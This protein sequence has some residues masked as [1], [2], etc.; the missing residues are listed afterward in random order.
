VNWLLRKKQEIWVALIHSMCQPLRHPALMSASRSTG[1]DSCLP[2]QPIQFQGGSDNAVPSRT[3][4]LHE[5]AAFRR[6][7]GKLS[8]KNSKS[9]QLWASSCLDANLSAKSSGKQWPRLA[10][11]V[12]VTSRSEDN[13]SLTVGAIAGKHALRRVVRNAAA[14]ADKCDQRS[15][16]SERQLQSARRLKANPHAC[17]LVA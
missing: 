8:P 17:T 7:P 15:G 16:Y 5:D 6:A 13:A 14:L 2:T 11:P 12:A 4:E 3:G 9:R 10:E 1:V